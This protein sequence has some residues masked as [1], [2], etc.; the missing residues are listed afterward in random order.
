MLNYAPTTVADRMFYKSF[1]S[2]RN[3][4][5]FR[6]IFLLLQSV[7]LGGLLLYTKLDLNQQSVDLD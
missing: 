3:G 2:I 4:V 6:A 1:S 7:S 5:L